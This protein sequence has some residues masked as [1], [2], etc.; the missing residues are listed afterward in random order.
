MKNIK[1]VHT[2]DIFYKAY[3]DGIEIEDL[4]SI[5]ITKNPGE[6]MRVEL[7]AR[8]KGEVQVET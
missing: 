2:G 4:Y 7:S 3:I 5:K 1:I 6:I 8:L